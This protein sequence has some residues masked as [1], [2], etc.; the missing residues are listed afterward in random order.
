VIG[1]SSAPIL[2][3]AYAISNALDR[4][5]VRKREQAQ[6]RRTLHEMTVRMFPMRSAA[7]GPA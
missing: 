1:N 6:Y 7:C 5:A 4:D 3:M 2:T